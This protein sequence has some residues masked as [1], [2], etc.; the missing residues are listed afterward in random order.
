MLRSGAVI[1]LPTEY[2]GTGPRVTLILSCG[3]SQRRRSSKIPRA[4]RLRCPSCG[5]SYHAIVRAEFIDAPPEGLL[6]TR[7]LGALPRLHGSL[8]NARLGRLLDPAGT[9]AQFVAEYP[10]A[11]IPEAVDDAF[12]NW[13]AGFADG[14]GHFA[15]RSKGPSAYT[16]AFGIQLRIDDLAILE[17]CKERT[18]LGSI[19]TRSRKDPKIRPQS[20]WMVVSHYDCEVLAAI[21]TRNPLRAK[22]AQD[23]E[24][25]KRA[26]LQWRESGRHRGGPGRWNGPLDQSAMRAL[27][28][29]I[30]AI[31]KWKDPDG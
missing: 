22:K 12:G 23:F 8:S 2:D 1:P 25:W 27:K 30:Q 10:V 16:C 28:E 19:H 29:E 21:F 4:L 24:V 5:E 11:V 26:L 9:M 13:L 3:H 15:I 31:R 7:D 14:E 18:G 6:W 17:E 20:T